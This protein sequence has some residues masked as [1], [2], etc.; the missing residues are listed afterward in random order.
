MARGTGAA[1]KAGAEPGHRVV[2][3]YIVGIAWLALCVALHFDAQAKKNAAP[4]QPV[5]IQLD[6]WSLRTGDALDPAKRCEPPAL[7][8]GHWF[9]MDCPA[10]GNF[11]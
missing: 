4:P 5:A 1:G 3:N 7:I 2:R 6:T 11:Q 8:D 9:P 10:E